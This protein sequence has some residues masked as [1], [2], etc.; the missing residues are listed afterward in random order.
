VAEG[1]GRALF[2]LLAEGVKRQ[3]TWNLCTA[4]R[5][6]SFINDSKEKTMH[7]MHGLMNVYLKVL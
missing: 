3:P 6:L 1:A 4:R 2:I 5:K 7:I